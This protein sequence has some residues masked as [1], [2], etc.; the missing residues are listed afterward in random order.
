MDLGLGFGNLDVDTDVRGSMDLGTIIE[1]QGLASVDLGSS[2]KD[3][4]P[5]AGVK[6]PGSMDPRMGDRSPMHGLDGPELGPSVNG[7]AVGAEDLRMGTGV[8]SSALMDFGI[9]S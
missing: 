9:K 4:V 6:G 3:L 5:S 2:S 7:L 1:V 8:P